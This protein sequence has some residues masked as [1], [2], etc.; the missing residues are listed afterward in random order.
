[1]NKNKAT[2]FLQPESQSALQ[3][4]GNW[5][6]TDV[7]WPISQSKLAVRNAAS[8]KTWVSLIKQSLINWKGKLPLEEEVREICSLCLSQEIS[9]PGSCLHCDTQL[10]H[11]GLLQSRL[12][13]LVPARTLHVWARSWLLQT[14]LASLIWMETYRLAPAENLAALSSVSPLQVGFKDLTVPS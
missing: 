8:G 1:M 5:V 3:A 11:A 9:P 10:L 13:L 2:S 7:V 6:W 14:G 12:Y 4:T